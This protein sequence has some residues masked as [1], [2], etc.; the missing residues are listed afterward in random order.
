MTAPPARFR[1]FDEFW[2][3]Y[4][5]EHR[6]PATRALHFVGTNVAVLIAGAAIATGRHWLWLVALAS[7]YAMAWIGHFFVERNRP[8]TFRYPL[9]SFAGDWKMWGLTWSGRLGA[10]LQRLDAAS[11]G[12]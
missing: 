12:P 4:L 3:F 6:K 8:A 5:G 1:S 9:W 11:P 7:A 2:L 10:E